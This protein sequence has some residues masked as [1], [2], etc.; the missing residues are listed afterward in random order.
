MVEKQKTGLF[1]S[2][3]GARMTDSDT[4]DRINLKIYL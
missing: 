4:L 3:F 1:Y 2:L